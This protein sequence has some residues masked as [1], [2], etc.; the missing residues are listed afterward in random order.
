MTQMY[1]ITTYVSLLNLKE[2]DTGGKFKYFILLNFMVTNK[3]LKN[4]R[5]TIVYVFQ[6]KTLT[7]KDTTLIYFS[8][9][10]WDVDLFKS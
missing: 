9:E 8:S 10:S 5:F 3:S 7:K 4:Q 1:D 2:F 6:P